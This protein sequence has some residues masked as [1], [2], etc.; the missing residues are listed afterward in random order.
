M[1][2]KFS[3]MSP[4]VQA[5]PYLPRTREYRISN[6][7]DRDN[8]NTS[9]GQSRHVNHRTPTWAPHAKHHASNPKYSSNKHGAPSVY[10]STSSTIAVCLSLD[11]SPPLPSSSVLITPSKHHMNLN[12]GS[13]TAGIC[14][15]QKHLLR[16]GGDAYTGWKTQPRTTNGLTP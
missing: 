1:S 8:P 12:L 15:N 6:I 7:G 14:L 13:T 5:G 16:R 4:P 11:P 2:P 10:S 9:K 3:I